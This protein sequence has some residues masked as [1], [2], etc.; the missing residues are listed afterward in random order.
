[1]VCSLHDLTERNYYNQSMFFL[2]YTL[3]FLKHKENITHFS[4]KR[5]G[6]SIQI[7]SIYLFLREIKRSIVIPAKIRYPWVIFLSQRAR[8]ILPSI[9]L[10][11]GCN[12]FRLGFRFS[13]EPLQNVS[14]AVSSRQKSAKERNLYVIN[15]HFEPIFSAEMATQIVL[16]GFP[17][18]KWLVRE[19]EAS[20]SSKLHGGIKAREISARNAICITATDSLISRRLIMRV[21]CFFTFSSNSVPHFLLLFIPVR[22]TAKGF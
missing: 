6:D 8:Q 18:R 10:P 4:K 14:E 5:L 2:L 16:Q 21:S 13:E 22:Q 3:N 20:A 9:A 11:A 17:N 7:P 15:E 1:M 12:Y 19:P